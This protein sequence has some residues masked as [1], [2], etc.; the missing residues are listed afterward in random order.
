MDPSS[1]RPDAA[2]RSRLSKSA[3]IAPQRVLPL[4]GLLVVQCAALAGFA[5]ALLLNVSGSYLATAAAAAT[6]AVVIPVRGQSIVGAVR[7][8]VAFLHDRRRRRRRPPPS[9]EP[10]DADQTDGTKIGFRWDG[11]VLVSVLRIG[12]N[13]QTMTVLEPASVVSGESVSAAVL[14]EC[15]E[16]FGI[17]LASIDVVSQGSRSHGR[18]RIAAIYDAVLGPLPAIARRSVW[19]VVRFDPTLCA[20]AI[21]R[22]GGDWQGIVRTA[23]TATRRVANRLA[24]AGL[25]PELATASEMTDAAADLAHGADLDEVD[26]EW[27][28]CRHR[29]LQLRSFVFEPASFTNASLGRLW[30]VPSLSTTVCVSLRRTDRNRLLQLRGLVRFA[31][32][33]QI[34]LD[35]A[36]LGPLPGSQYAALA[37]TLPIPAPRRSVRHWVVGASEQELHDLLLPVSGCGQVIGADHHGR[38]IALPLF[39]PGVD[40]V[41]ICG[42]LHLAQQVVLRSI[43]LGARVHVRTRRPSSWQ[44]MANQV[45]D[46]DRLRVLGDEE[47]GGDATDATSSERDRSVV[48]FDGTSERPASTGGTAVVVRPAHAVPSTEADV[49][50]VLLDHDRDLVRV[51]TAAGSTV[52]TMVATED[53]MRFL[54]PVVRHV[55]S[56]TPIPAGGPS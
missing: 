11:E 26:E 8:R 41:E 17:A 44:V 48:V 5:A 1:A 16:Q 36:G 13:P 40:R 2:A 50:L 45:G 42:T 34:R 30:S 20:D 46:R 10:F 39:G 23:S 37:D 29:R 9:H 43:A 31:D 32:H 3:A 28:T 14:A 51:G 24:D 27:L 53:E 47:A 22:R 33:Q 56:A 6:A 55:G 19:V 7:D 25:H 35:L 18:S 15:L 38:A 49:S 12:A 52:V 21:R 54:K 4:P